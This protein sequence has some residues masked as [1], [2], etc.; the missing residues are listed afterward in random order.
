[1]ALLSGGMPFKALLAGA[2]AVAWMLLAESALGATVA[3]SNETFV[4][5]AAVGEI[6]D[7]SIVEAPEGVFTIADL[8]ATITPQAGECT[9]ISPSAV[10]CEAPFAGIQVFTK[11]GADSVDVASVYA[12]VHGGAGPDTLR[13]A[14]SLP[15]LF[16]GPGDDRLIGRLGIQELRGGPGADSLDGGRGQDRLRGGPGTDVIAGGPGRDVAEYHDHRSP[17]WISLDG[18]ANDGAAGE[19]DWIRT[20]VENASGS[21]G[22]TTFIGN[23]GPNTF[24]CGNEE[25]VVRAG[26]GNDLV[27]A[28]GGPDIVLGGPGND[29]LFGYG[30]GDVIRGGAGN[31]FIYGMWGEDDLGGGRGGDRVWAGVQNDV[32]RGGPGRDRLYGRWGADVFYTRDRSQDRVSGGAADDRARVDRID[33]V[34]SIEALF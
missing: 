15:T 25:D 30:G 22:P 2:A 14:R 5:E 28:W 4:Y 33:A 32:L 27:Y 11:D 12:V 26:A 16:G 19:G 6:N 13:G 9:S 8:N 7:V 29:A 18:R 10:R 20:D 34:W 24:W 23:A 17:V 21:R 3:F 1:M 31:D